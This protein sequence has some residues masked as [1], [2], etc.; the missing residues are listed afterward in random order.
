MSFL[1]R[2]ASP[3]ATA[4]IAGRMPVLTSV[5]SAAASL[6][7]AGVTYAQPSAPPLRVSFEIS[8]D[9]SLG[10]GVASTSEMHAALLRTV[11]QRLVGE[12]GRPV[13]HVRPADCARE[14]LHVLLGRAAVTERFLPASGEPRQRTI[15]VAGDATLWP[16]AV[17]LLAGNLVRDEAA[18]LLATLPAD[19]PAP[20]IVAP[21]PAAPAPA[22]IADPSSAPITSPSTS[23]STSPA[24]GANLVTSAAA[25]GA[26]GASSS[27][28]APPVAVATTVAPLKPHTTVSFG[29]VPILST[30]LLGIGAVGHDV[31]LDLAVGVSGG[32]RVL[33]V[34]GAVDIELG[35]VSGLQLAGAVVTAEE[36]RGA[37]VAGAIAYATEVRGTQVAGALS[38][39]STVRGLQIGGALAIATRSSGSQVAGAATLSGGDAGAQVA[40]ALAMSG[41]SVGTQISGAGSFARGK[42]GL[43]VAGAVSVAGGNA[44]TQISGAL[45]IAGGTTHTQISGA[46]NIARDVEGVQIGTLNIAREVS[47]VQVGV[48]NIGGGDDG[49]SL[50]LLNIVP[51]GRTDLEAS[52]DSEGIG[53][54]LLRHGSRRWHNVY[55][56]GGQRINQDLVDGMDDVWMYGLGFGPSWRRGATNFDL[57]AMAWEVN[58]GKQH[59]DDISLLA[60]LRLSVAHDL[61]PITLVGGGAINTFISNDPRQ[62]FLE[63]QTAMPTSDEVETKSWLSAF[64][65]VRL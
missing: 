5:L 45:N 63:R 18:S 62:P 24:A 6:F 10:A 43:Q 4:R 65:G 12:L 2:P 28:I 25:S 1:S 3:R 17:A 57:E 42:A 21:A 39:A 59:S 32:S 61:G 53:T 19:L 11:E 31:S 23:P 49:I 58:Y 34:G 14:C 47:G 60:Q 37:Q 36:L 33:S 38:T 22:V 44:A 41:G 30:D 54:V 52:L 56:V 8:A 9:A 29:L 16:D 40:G 13:Q 46:V 27:S 26:P 55:G 7:S 48:V 50:G 64:V 51:G 15:D 35:P 20:P